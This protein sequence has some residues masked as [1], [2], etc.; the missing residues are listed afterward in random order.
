MRYTYFKETLKRA[1]ELIKEDDCNMV[2]KVW[3]LFEERKINVPVEM[4]V[5]YIDE[6]QKRENEDYNYWH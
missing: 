4:V 6:E 3:E 2:E 5:K 1:N